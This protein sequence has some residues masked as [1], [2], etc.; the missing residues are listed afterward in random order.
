MNKWIKL[1]SWTLLAVSLTAQSQAVTLTGAARVKITLN[2]EGNTKRCTGNIEAEPNTAPFWHASGNPAGLIE[3]SVTWVQGTFNSIDLNTRASDSN[4][5]VL[6]ISL[7]SGSVTGVSLTAGVFSGTPSVVQAPTPVFRVCDPSSLCTD[8]GITFNIEAAPV[9]DDSVPDL[10]TFVSQTGVA[11]SSIV[12]STP[13]V[14][15]SGINVASTVTVSTGT[16]DKNSS[17]VFTASAGSVVAGDTVR[18]RHTADASNNASV[19][20]TLTVGGVSATFTSTTVNSPARVGVIYTGNFDSLA[21]TARNPEQSFFPNTNSI[22]DGMDI[23][24]ICEAEWQAPAAVCDTEGHLEI[25]SSNPTPINGAFAARGTIYLLDTFPTAIY[26]SGPT[27]HKFQTSD[28]PRVDFRMA[29]GL[30]NTITN[31]DGPGLKYRKT[32]FMSVSKFIYSDYQEHCEAGWRETHIQWHK[33][34]AVQTSD[35]NGQLMLI[36]KQGGGTTWRLELDR[37]PIGGDV[38]TPLTTTYDVDL[39]D[40]MKNHYNIWTFQFNIDNRPVASGGSPLMKAVLDVCPNGV[41]NISQCTRQIVANTTTHW[42]FDASSEAK[43]WL[44][45]WNTPYPGSVRG[46]TQGPYTDCKTGSIRGALDAIR[47]GDRTSD[48]ASVHPL[49][50]A[51]PAGW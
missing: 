6:T 13:P 35:N 10:F 49:Q 19:Q 8:I 23:K 29:N 11:V 20:T 45:A 37:A 9:P 1:L 44:P 5:D 34:P 4:G 16:W 41:T 38:S 42:G 33:Q 51:P 28:K 14:V 30:A 15:I 40:D 47:I 17:G 50:A 21:G 36:G 24:H 3:S 27:G 31:A 12:T 43:V 26:K 48:F 18:V 2:C 32:Y 46:D 22:I 39:T 7:L 25:I